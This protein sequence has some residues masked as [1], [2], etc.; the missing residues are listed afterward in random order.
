VSILDVNFA[1]VGAQAFAFVLL[2]LFFGKV[3]LPSVGKQLDERRVEIAST[4]DQ[5]AADRKAMEQ[6]RADYEQRLATIAEEAREQGARAMHQAQSEAAA[7][8]AKARA[9]TAEFRDRSMAEL[10]QER[11][12]AVAEIRSQMA[13]LAVVAASKILEREINPAVHRELISDM[14]NDVSAGG[15]RPS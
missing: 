10:D 1:T 4:L 7:L 5:I 3:V 9:E 15:A 6:T 11:K 13:D 2:A 8:L 12:K 14:I